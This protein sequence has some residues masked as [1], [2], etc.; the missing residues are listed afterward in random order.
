M[1][2]ETKKVF[3]HTFV[4]IFLPKFSKRCRQAGAI[5]ERQRALRGNIRAINER[6]RQQYTLLQEQ[7]KILQNCRM[8]YKVLKQLLKRWPTCQE[9]SREEKKCL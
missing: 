5:N 9:Q 2:S 4:T 3:D 1:F 8:K 7:I 6:Q